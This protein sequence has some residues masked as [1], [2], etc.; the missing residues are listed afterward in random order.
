MRKQINERPQMKHV[1][2]TFSTG[3]VS[4]CPYTCKLSEVLEI[5]AEMVRLIE[6]GGAKVASVEIV[7][8]D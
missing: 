6:S 5:T 7:E 1:K 3:A 2:I 4:L 8:C